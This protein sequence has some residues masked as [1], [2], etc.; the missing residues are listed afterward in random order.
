MEEDKTKGLAAKDDHHK[1]IGIYIHIPFCVRKCLYCDFLSFPAGRKEQERYV[2]ALCREMGAESRKYADHVVNTVFL[3]GGT[4]SLLPGERIQEILNT[5]YRYYKVAEDCEISIEVNPG[6]IT[7]QKL[8]CWREGGVNRLS[9]GLQSTVED[10][11]KALGRIHSREDFFRTYELA[12]DSGFHNINIDLMFGIPKQTLSSYSGTLKTVVTLR[13]RPTHI[14]AYS[15]IVE[16]GTPFFENVPELPDEDTE[17]EMDKITN[18]ILSGEGYLQ[19]EISNHALPGFRCRHNQAYWRRGDYV[20]FG[21][22]AASLVGDMRFNNT[23]DIKKY[24]DFYESCER[25]T[26]DIKKDGDIKEDLQLLSKEEQMEE[27]MFLGLRMREGV[28]TD[29][30]FRIFGVTIDG[31]YPG[32]VDDFCKKGLLARKRRPDGGGEWIHLTRRGIDVSNVVMA[33]FLLERH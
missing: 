20:G 9:I 25:K 1:N 7:P 12:V 21:I 19:Y 5:V 8:K 13:P 17:R 28:S 32:I 10:E 29:E 16:E 4:P 15:L 26:Y 30:F 23:R 33:E 27:F 24:E 3:G 14:S 2:K 22:G 31:V 6:T 18:E 11:L